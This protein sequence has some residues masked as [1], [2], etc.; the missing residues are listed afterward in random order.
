MLKKDND[1]LSARAFALGAV[2]IVL[3]WLAAAWF[4]AHIYTSR[5]AGKVYAA[6]RNKAHSAITELHEGLKKSLTYLYVVPDLASREMIFHRTLR[7]LNYLGSFA[8]MQRQEIREIL[9]QNP[10]GQKA[11]AEFAKITSDIDSISV[12]WLIRKDGTCIASS[13]ADTAESFVGVNYADRDYFKAAISGKRGQQY[14]MGRQTNIPGIFFSAPVR[15]GNEIPGI[16]VAKVDLPYLS[17]WTK[18]ANG[19]VMDEYGVIV[20]GANHNY[21]MMALPGATVHDLSEQTRLLRY[22]L[23]EIRTLDIQPWEND[24]GFEL[25]SVHNSSTPGYIL[26]SDLQNFNLRLMVLVESA[27]LG[28]VTK[29]RKNLFLALAA[30][31]SIFIILVATL[32]YHFKALQLSRKARQRQ[33]LIEQLAHYDALTG[34][35]S[36]SLTEQLISQCIAVASENSAKFAILFCDIDLFKEINNSFGYEIGDEALQALAG[37]I[38]SSLKDSDIIIRHGGDEFVILLHGITEP[39]DVATIAS[40]LMAAISQPLLVQETSIELSA[41]IGISLYPYDG[42]TP[43]LL[44]RHA[45]AAL[46]NVKGRG[47]ADYSFYQTKM[48]V[49][50]AAR[51]A[52]EADMVRALE[53]N[54]FFLVYQPKYSHT[55]GGISG[56]EALIRWKHNSGRII[57]PLEFIPAA[58]RSGFI[59]VLGEWVVN[60]ACRQSKEWGQTL[61]EVIPIAVNLSAV[62]FQRSDLVDIIRRA[63]VRH[64]IEPGALDLEVTESILMTDTQQTLDIMEE[65][66]AFGARFSIDDFGT[67]Y[68]SLAYLQQFAADT[69]KIDRVFV[70]NMENDTN[71]LAITSAIISMAKNLDYEIIAEG[72]ENREQYELLLEMGCTEIQGFW[73]S[74]PLTAEA[75]TEFYREIRGRETGI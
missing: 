57:P 52:M 26:H 27:D 39:D 6:T 16:I 31:G 53:E 41:S 45:E 74:R 3:V 23:A 43:Q 50:M 24:P 75:F 1:N 58:E 22:K 63:I 54:E 55:K 42:E 68:S 25:H 64:N 15:V 62:Q 20:L 47:R 51:R 8:G 66:R 13:N 10:S 40:R 28:R 7:E 72:V 44:L 33:E 56:C 11:S 60:E 9:S 67:G 69:L 70:C 5:Q 19:F 17:Y 29:N 34:L 36:R 4:F 2:L 48:S 73:F 18:Q 21:E 35:Y 38:K 30:G 37:R 32:T 12:L 65:I 59:R 46:H 61:G 71:A 49:D 14:A